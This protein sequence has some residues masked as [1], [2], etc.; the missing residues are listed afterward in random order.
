MDAEAFPIR[1]T[2]AVRAYWRRRGYH[3]LVVATGDGGG[4]KATRRLR[5]RARV[6]LAGPRRALA[7]ARCGVLALARKASAVALPGGGGL[8]A[9][10]VPRRRKQLPSAGQLT[11]FEQRLMLE[12]YK[13]IV[14]SKE[15]AT[16]LRYSAAAHLAK[17]TP[18]A[19]AHGN[20][21]QAVHLLDM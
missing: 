16:M 9:R 12:M 19:H 14:A 1:F 17:T 8:W 5:L 11:A 21:R 2:R 15:L 3:R 7:R 13:S 20:A 6:V 18:A 10:L 4:G